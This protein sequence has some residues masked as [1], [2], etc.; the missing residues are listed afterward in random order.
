M[1][2]FRIWLV[3]PVAA[4]ALS[5]SGCIFLRS[6]SISDAAGNG[7]PINAQASDLGYLTLIPPGD[8]PRWRPI[9]SSISVQAAR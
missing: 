6:S 3:A 5:L 7:N 9:I 1:S 4:A 8:L 2:R